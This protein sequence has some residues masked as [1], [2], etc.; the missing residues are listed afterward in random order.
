MDEHAINRGR[1]CELFVIPYQVNDKGVY[2]GLLKI[3]MPYSKMKTI[4]KVNT[5]KIC[6]IY[7]ATTFGGFKLY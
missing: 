1:H 5:C 7:G 3:N 4:L 2:I 6:E